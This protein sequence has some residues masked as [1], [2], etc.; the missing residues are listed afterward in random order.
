M[1][2]VAAGPVKLASRGA[3]YSVTASLHYYCSAGCRT[4]TVGDEE[5]SCSCERNVCHHRRRCQLLLQGRMR[6]PAT[7]VIMKMKH[8]HCVNRLPVDFS[9]YHKP[10]CCVS[11]LSQAFFSFCVCV[12]KGVLLYEPRR[13]THTWT[14]KQSISGMG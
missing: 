8:L 7:S 10:Q 9:A 12:R 14:W 3:V 5:T 2:A 1:W 11:V 13:S 4:I 6:S